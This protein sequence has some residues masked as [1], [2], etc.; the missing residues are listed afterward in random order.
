MTCGNRRFN[1]WGQRPGEVVSYEQDFLS[2]LKSGIS[3]VSIDSLSVGA[4]P[5]TILNE[6]I[7]LINATWRG[8]LLMSSVGNGI[9]KIEATFSDGQ[10]FFDYFHINTEEEIAVEC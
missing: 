3:V 4:D 7:D 10:V 2:V 6:T 9:V 1:N 5:V 8:Q